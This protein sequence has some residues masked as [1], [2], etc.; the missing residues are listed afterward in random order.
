VVGYIKKVSNVSDEARMLLGCARALEE[1]TMD[2]WMNDTEPIESVLETLKS[3]V[4]TKFVEA[5]IVAML[6][7][8][9]KAYREARAGIDNLKYTAGSIVEDLVFNTMDREKSG[10]APAFRPP[11]LSVAQR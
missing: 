11:K 8:D 7:G 5:K 2:S 10:M 3:A 9:R 4:R 1:N 6:D